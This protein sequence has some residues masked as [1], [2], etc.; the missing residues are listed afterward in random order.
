M[1]QLNPIVLVLIVCLGVLAGWRDDQPQARPE[2]IDLAVMTFNIRYGTADDGPNAWPKRKDLVLDVLHTHA[3]DIVGMQEALR[4]Q[5]D[6]II[7]AMPRYGEIGVGRADG[8]EAGEYSAIL[9]DAQRFAVDDHGTFWLSDSPEAVASMSWGNRIPR[10]CTWARLIEKKSQTTFYVFNTH[11]DHESQP[12]REKSAVL[13]AKRMAARAHRADT[14]IL[15]GDFNASEMNDAIRYLKGELPC[16]D[17]GEAP[18]PAAAEPPPIVLVDTFRVLHPEAKDVG[19][20]C[21]FRGTTDGPKIDYV[22]VEPRVKVLDAAIVRDHD[23]G[24][25]PSDHFPVKATIRLDTPDPKD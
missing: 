1:R 23:E 12:S 22:F 13:L 11:L 14:V 5:L 6:Q 16:V 15:T 10:I 8:K 2:S 7:G 21:G 3:P 25:Y 17:E 20:F 24:R 19:T 9:Y 18:P 4:F